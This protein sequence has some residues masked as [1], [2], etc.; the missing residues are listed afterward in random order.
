MGMNMYL[1]FPRQLVLIDHRIGPDYA[2]DASGVQAT[3]TTGL[4]TI[5]KYGTYY[6][7][8]L[9]SKQVSFSNP[10]HQFSKPILIKPASLAILGYE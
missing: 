5:R 10:Q 2:F 6:N 8:A 9:W 4:K 1:F 7:I 3:L